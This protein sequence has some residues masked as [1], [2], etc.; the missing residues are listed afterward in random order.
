ME[1]LKFIETMTV[2]EFKALFNTKSIKVKRNPET[3][4]LFMV[5]GDNK[6][7][8]CCQSG[9]PKKPVVSKVEN[10]EGDTFWMIHNESEGAETLATF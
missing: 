1:K 5:Y 10:E 4:K 8:A 6:V 2:E 3:A 9:I 7:G